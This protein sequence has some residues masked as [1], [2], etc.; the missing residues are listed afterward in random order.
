[1]KNINETEIF[2]KNVQFLRKKLKISKTQMAKRL[3]ISKHSMA[4]IERGEMPP[5]LG[6]E[7]LVIIFNEFCIRP[8]DMF[9]PLFEVE[10]IQKTKRRENAN[11]AKRITKE[12]KP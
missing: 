11:S 7:I 2:C 1:M 8:S 4:K 6:C 5:R 10:E 9:L 3:G 12:K